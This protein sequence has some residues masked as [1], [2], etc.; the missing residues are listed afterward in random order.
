[1]FRILLGIVEYYGSIL[2]FY[3]TSARA[4]CWT[5]RTMATHEIGCKLVKATVH[6]QDKSTKVL[7]ENIREKSPDC[8][9][10]SSLSESL[11]AIQDRLNAFLTD[12]VEEERGTIPAAN[13]INNKADEEGI[14]QIVNFQGIGHGEGPH[15]L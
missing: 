12:I 2:G 8:S 10:L 5:D 4:N 6:L 1:M 15:C 13:N 9:K 7:S 11:L 14:S 3:N